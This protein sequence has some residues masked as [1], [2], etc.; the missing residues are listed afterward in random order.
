V[1]D[2]LGFDALPGG[3]QGL[4]DSGQRLG[5]PVPVAGDGVGDAFGVGGLPGRGQAC[6]TPASAS[7]TP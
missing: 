7:R 5:F 2:P 1:G 3:G 6:A 4:R